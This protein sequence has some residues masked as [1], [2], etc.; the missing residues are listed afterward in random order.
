MYKHFEQI[1]VFINSNKLMKKKE[2]KFQQLPR[3][4]NQNGPVRVRNRTS[5]KI[6][7]TEKRTRQ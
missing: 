3:N 4:T 7:E 6:N 2:G 1:Y 5:G